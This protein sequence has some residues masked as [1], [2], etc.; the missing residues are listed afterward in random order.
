MLVAGCG[1]GGGAGLNS[2]D[3]AVVG[4]VHIA[5]SEYDALIDQAQRSFKQQGRPFPKQGT[6]D[7]QSIRGNAVTL[8]VQQAERQSKADSMGIEVTDKD[9]QNRLD[10]IIKQYFQNKKSKYEAQLKKQHLTDAQV[11][12]DIRSQL[13]LRGRLQQGH[14]G[15]EGERRRRARLLHRAPGALLAAA[16]ARRPL[17]P[18]QVEGHRRLDLQP[19]QGRQHRRVVSAREEV[20]EGRERPELRQGDLLKGPDGRGLRQD[21][22]L[23]AD[24]EG[25]HAVLRPDAVQVVVRRSSR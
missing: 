16:V 11:R 13:D 18:R 24:E 7:F 9:V 2:D 23:A 25:A 10:Q 21:R 5:K 17:H 8:L 20:R 22:V 12:K 3:V 4:D 1:G 14:E 19:G 6:T 15:R